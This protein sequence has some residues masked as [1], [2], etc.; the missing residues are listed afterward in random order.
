MKKIAIV[1]GHSNRSKGACNADGLCE[2]TYN[3]VLADLISSTLVT[4]GDYDPIV[5]YR[6]TYRD[7]PNKINEIEP[8]LI[9]SL[10]CNAFNTRA[11]GTETLYHHRSSMGREFAKIVQSSM[12]NVLGLPDR[13]V[14]PK[15]S[16]DRGGYLLR[17]THAPCLILEPFFID[18]ESDLQCG[19]DLKP[20]LA[21]A[22]AYSIKKFTEE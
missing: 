8:N 15:T 19:L 17:Y 20:E 21:G 5:V 3:T 11:S 16:E 22:I 6:D 10:H 2:Y 14:K 1:V 13:G 18:N 9:I 4:L 7:L 12:V